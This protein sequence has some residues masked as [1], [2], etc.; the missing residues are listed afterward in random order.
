MKTSSQRTDDETATAPITDPRHMLPKGFVQAP[1]GMLAS[2]SGTPPVTEA[3]KE[4]EGEGT[5]GDGNQ[6]P[7]SIES[8]E[9]RRTARRDE[10]PDLCVLALGSARVYRGGHE[11]SLSSWKYARTREMFFFLLSHPPCTKEQIGRA[12]WP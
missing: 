5:P 12:L 9:R 10:L 6:P 11:I 2:V 3:H 4:I 7:A 8:E 1:A